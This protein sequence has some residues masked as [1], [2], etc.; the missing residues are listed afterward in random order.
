MSEWWNGWQSKGACRGEDVALFFAPNY[1]ERRSAKGAREAKAKLLCRAC[2]V[3][4]ECRAYALRVR[5]EHGVW[6]G[7][8]EAERRRILRLQEQ[9]TA[10]GTSAAAG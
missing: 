4:E 5:E 2:P 1:F 9:E 8:N 10:A 7:L 6:G 3:L